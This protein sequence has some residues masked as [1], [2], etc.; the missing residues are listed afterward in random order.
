M[1]YCLWLLFLAVVLLLPLPTLAFCQFPQPRLVCAEY[2]ASQLVVEAT[3]IQT[4]KLHDKDDPEGLSAYVYTLR[5]NQILRGK[6]T[7]TIQVYEGNDSGR[8]GFNW[9]ARREYLLF[10]FQSPDHQGSWALDGCGN[11]GPVGKAKIALSEIA[12]I[13]AAHGGG[14]I[15]GAAS[16]Q[17]L[18]TPI[19]GVH[20]E[21]RGVAGHYTAAT[22]EKGEFQLNVPPGR[23][24]VVATKDGVT[25]DTADISY[26]NPQKIQ[27]EPGGCA[28]VQFAR[29]EHQS[30]K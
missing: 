25:F 4:D 7:E 8:A 29:P 22:N 1:K 10:L 23:Y 9:L 13:K 15:H 16:E 17:A 20:V 30:T 6:I 12:L 5:V 18:S 27:I 3:L 26:E 28:Q 14:V 21:A 24:T 19:A 2:F 11:S